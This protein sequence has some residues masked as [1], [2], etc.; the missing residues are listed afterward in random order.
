[1]ANA[2]KAPRDC[3]NMNAENETPAAPHSTTRFQPCD[4][5]H[6]RLVNIPSATEKVATYKEAKKLGLK[7]VPLALSSPN[8]AYCA[9][10]KS[11][12]N[13]PIPTNTIMT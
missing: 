3:A 1:M 4:S 2:P 9:I 5:L 11:P 13:M 12:S 8:Q 6:G 7:N 10:P